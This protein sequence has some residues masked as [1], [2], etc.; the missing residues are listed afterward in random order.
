MY[1]SLQIVSLQAILSAS[2]VAGRMGQRTN[3]IGKKCRAFPVFI[4]SSI[5]PRA[6]RTYQ[7]HRGSGIRGVFGPV[8]SKYQ[9]GRSSYPVQSYPLLDHRAWT[10]AVR[11]FA[12][13]RMDASWMAGSAQ[14][15][16]TLCYV[17]VCGEGLL[18]ALRILGEMQITVLVADVT[19][20]DAFIMRLAD[21]II[22]RRRSWPTYKCCANEATAPKSSFGGRASHPSTSETSSYCSTRGESA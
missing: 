1:T 3:W 16:M 20:E 8:R 10:N 4:K 9:L 6:C 22:A 2:H 12:L 5:C 21:N 13:I 17:L 19:D 11:G 15:T 14:V 7:A 18:Y